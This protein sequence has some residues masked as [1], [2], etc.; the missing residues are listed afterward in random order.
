[1]AGVLHIRKYK[2]SAAQALIICAAVVCYIY[3]TILGKIR[4]NNSIPDKP[5]G[6]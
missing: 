2:E 5:P 4:T 1:M 3:A 6:T